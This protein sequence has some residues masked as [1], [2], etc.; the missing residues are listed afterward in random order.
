MV[1]PGQN[2]TY[3]SRDEVWNAF[4]AN[5]DTVW[6]HQ[7]QHAHSDPPRFTWNGA[8]SSDVVLDIQ[9]KDELGRLRVP[10]VSGVTFDQVI[11][12]A[13]GV[14]GLAVSYSND[15]DSG[16][17]GPLVFMTCDGVYD[18]LCNQEHVSLSFGG[19][20][21]QYRY[22]KIVFLTSNTDALR[23]QEFW[24][25]ADCSDDV[26]AV[27]VACWMRCD[28]PAGLAVDVLCCIFPFP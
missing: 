19:Q 5:D 26:D 22:W 10:K 28:C 12:G 4:D 21:L 17:E 11:T 9:S 18:S 1:T 20:S 25:T 23:I 6:H 27:G 3:A 16:F 24:F 2:C 14:T 15:L 8:L 7:Q 13:D